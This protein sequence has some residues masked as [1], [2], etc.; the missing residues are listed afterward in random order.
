MVK[1][2][3]KNSSR[4]SQFVF[5]GLLLFAFLVIGGFAI[6]QN[7]EITL[8]VN[9]TMMSMDSPD[10]QE[11]IGITSNDGLVVAYT[12]P[13]SR[14]SQSLKLNGAVQLSGTKITIPIAL[15]PGDVALGKSMNQVL[16]VDLMDTL[17]A[18]DYTVEVI[19][20]E[21]GAANLGDSKPTATRSLTSTLTVK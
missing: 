5:A 7:N 21:L 17:E 2:S 6:F 8:E 11:N 3:K 4:K 15:T 12:S 9:T 1:K 10:V 16:N 13:A 18:G 20:S 19:V 14:M